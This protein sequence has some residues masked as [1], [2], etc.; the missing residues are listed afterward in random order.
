MIIVPVQ[1]SGVL[2][3]SFFASYVGS[4]VEV[5]AVQGEVDGRARTASF[6]GLAR[7]QTSNGY[8][9][10]T[11]GLVAELQTGRVTSNGLLEIRAPFGDLTAG[12]V[13]FQVATPQTGQQM[14]FTNGV[15]LLYKPIT[16]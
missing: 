1:K 14:L 2:L 13:T 16:P 7:L 11:N 10:E 15:S 4:F 12:M 3:R 5:T 9:M 8:E 6:L